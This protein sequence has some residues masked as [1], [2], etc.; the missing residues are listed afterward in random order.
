MDH[1]AFSPDTC[2]H[3]LVMSRM[4]SLPAPRRS[5]ASAV[6]S[7]DDAMRLYTL[8]VFDAALA[9]PWVRLLDAQDD[10]GAI[11]LAH[12]ILPSKRRELWDRRRLVAE[13]G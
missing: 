5:S 2:T 4:C 12:S 3:Y 10:K 13:F 1:T 11:A 8:C 9:V 7:P 6:L